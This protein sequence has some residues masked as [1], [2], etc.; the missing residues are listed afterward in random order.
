MRE[1]EGWEVEA[2]RLRDAGV[3]NAQT[4]AK[5]VKRQVRSVRKL[6][7]DDEACESHFIDRE[8]V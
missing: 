1:L 2:F 6:L 7:L 5:A 8:E 3:R 4:I